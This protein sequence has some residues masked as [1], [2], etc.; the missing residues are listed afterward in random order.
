MTGHFR[1]NFLVEKYLTYDASIQVTTDYGMT[2]KSRAGELSKANNYSIYG[3]R[4]GEKFEIV[5][6]E[7]FIPGQVFNGET[8]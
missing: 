7:G 3:I 1:C 8:E 2:A 5:P 6:K 4:I